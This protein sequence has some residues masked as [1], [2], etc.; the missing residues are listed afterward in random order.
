MGKLLAITLLTATALCA[1][2]QSLAEKIEVSLVSVD[3][4]VTSHGAPA[5]G[6]SRDDFEALVRTSGLPLS[7]AQKSGL[8]EAYGY[9]EAMAQRVRAGGKRPREA[10][11]AVIFKPA[12]KAEGAP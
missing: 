5:R 2:A 8:F 3:V 6:L 7:E 9:V 11:P 1:N 12:V 4:T 10:E